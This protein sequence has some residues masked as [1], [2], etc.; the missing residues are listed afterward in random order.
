MVQ[1]EEMTDSNKANED[2]L[3]ALHHMVAIKLAKMLKEAE[4]EPEMMLKVLREARGFL[5]D[6]EVSADISTSPSL[7]RL[8]EQVKVEELPFSIPDTKETE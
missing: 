6:N 7:P 3:N 5:K 4:G 2:M 8:A 1:G